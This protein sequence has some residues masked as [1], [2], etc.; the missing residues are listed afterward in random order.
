MSII[1]D[2]LLELQKNGVQIFVATHNYFLAKYLDI[3]KTKDDKISFYSFYKN[4]NGVGCEM[5]DGFTLLENN[6]IT[7]TY[8]KIYRDEL[9]V[10]L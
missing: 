4:D 10:S 7:K 2:I 1:A 3:K 6:A 8:L 5:A 9:G